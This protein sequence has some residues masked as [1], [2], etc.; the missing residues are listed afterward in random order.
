[1]LVFVS[2]SMDITH[3][4]FYLPI[5]QS[6]EVPVSSLITIGLLAVFLS[7]WAIPTSRPDHCLRTVVPLFHCIISWS[8]Y[9]LF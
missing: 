7:Y 1:M 2:E 9:H 3:N 5:N 6:L 4:K 8:S